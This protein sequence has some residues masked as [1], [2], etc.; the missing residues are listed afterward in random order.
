MNTKSST[1]A[2]VVGASDYL[3]NSIWVLMFL[4]AQGY[5][6]EESILEQDNESAIKLEKNGRMSAGQ[7]S[8]HIN[9]SFFWSKDRNKENRIRI[10]HCP[11]LEMLADFL[12]RHSRVSFSDTSGTS[13][14]AGNTSTPYRLS[15]RH[16][17]RSVLKKDDLMRAKPSARAR[18]M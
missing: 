7:K 3:P 4:K 9:I 2:E 18:V 16:C 5:P 13:Y 8:R 15:T 12:R 1:E 6:I 11:M 10:R 14:W 17:P